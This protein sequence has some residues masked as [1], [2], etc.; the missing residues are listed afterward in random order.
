[1]T[2][3]PYP[4]AVPPTSPA[5]SWQPERVEAVPGTEFG[6]VQLRVEP[7]TSGLAV[8]SLLAGIGSIL[9][10]VVVFCFGLLGADAGWGAQAAGAFTVLSLLGGG[11]AIVVGVAARRQVRRPV[12]PGQVRF[13]GNGVAIAGICCGAT[14]AGIAALSMALALMLQLSS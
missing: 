6:L 2:Q 3:Q 13:T 10:S 5:D 12:Q 14:G 7:I 8:G 9:V 11:G 4:P 1:M